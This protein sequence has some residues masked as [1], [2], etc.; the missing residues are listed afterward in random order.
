MFSRNDNF[1]SH[2]LSCGAIWFWKNPMITER[3]SHGRP[4]CIHN[5]PLREVRRGYMRSCS[6]CLIRMF[7]P[8]LLEGVK[9][10]L[11]S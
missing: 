7:K 8:P 2:C 4:V 6:I 11:Q 9:G 10:L 1:W 3:V 5:P